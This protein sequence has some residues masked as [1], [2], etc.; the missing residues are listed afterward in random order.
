MRKGHRF[1]QTVGVLLVVS[2]LGGPVFGQGNVSS[3]TLTIDPNGI[4]STYNTNGA[5]DT[6]NAFF[7]SLGTNGRTCNS[8]HVAGDAWSIAPLSLKVRFLL[9]AGTDPVFR[10][11][12]GAN[13]PSA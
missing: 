4:L 2:T 11:V 5:I 6:R 1:L 9:T 7:Q 12:D 3:Q 8:C 13:C 10:P